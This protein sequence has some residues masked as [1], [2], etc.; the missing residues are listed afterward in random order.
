MIFD[1]G[2]PAGA[3]YLKDVPYVA[4][5]WDV[6]DS[7]NGGWACGPTSSLMAMA[8]HKKIT[9]HP[10]VC[11]KPWVHNT[12]F[13][14]YDSNVYTSPINITFDR[15]QTDASGNPAWGAYGTCTENGG[16]WA[17][18]VQQYIENHGGLVATFYDQSDP[19]L[20]KD[21]INNGNLVVQSTQMS[22]AGHLVLIVGYNPDGTFLVNDPAGNINGPK[23]SMYP[24]G[25]YISYTWA[26]LHA[27]WCI[28]VSVAEGNEHAPPAPRNVF[29]DVTKMF[30]E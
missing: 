4:Q 21:S 14:Y 9:A 10:I 27:K 3:V 19:D 17:W 23:W 13:G 2:I 8:Y 29:T 28:V 1:C 25:A 16:A 15:M 12:S 6:G 26:T 7:F 11:S 20:L 30:Q 24:T 5:D 18:R 22:S